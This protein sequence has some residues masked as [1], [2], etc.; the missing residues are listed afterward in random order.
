M[1]LLIIST[2]YLGHEPAA[3]GSDGATGAES[4]GS[5]PYLESGEERR[6]RVGGANP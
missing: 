1:N 2:V 3:S 4:E 6:R 5:G